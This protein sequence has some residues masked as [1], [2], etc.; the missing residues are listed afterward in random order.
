M[1]LK[2]PATIQL[3]DGLFVPEGANLDEVDRRW[4]KLCEQNPACFDGALLHVLGTQRNGCGGATLHVMECSYRFFAV[5]N[6]T[7]DLGV[8]SLGTK[9]ITSFE[10]LFLFGERSDAVLRH[11]GEW[12]FAPA[13]C[14]EP[15]RNPLDVIKKE[16][17]EETGLTLATPPLAVALLFDEIA[18]TWE[19]VYRLYA[20]SNKISG[21]AEYKQ[22]KWLKKCEFPEVP[23][24]ITTMML[25]YAC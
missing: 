19:L 8:R 7:Y 2:R 23:S 15:N 21:N 12:E 22:L 11:A 25:P 10:E 16:L 3:Q 14:V 20:T 24:G 6:S 18:M 5:Q 1:L 9:G 4:E 13:G 17:S